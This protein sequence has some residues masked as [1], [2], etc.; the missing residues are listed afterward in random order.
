MR[1]TA[2]VLATTLLSLVTLSGL[3]TAGSGQELFRLDL[4]PAGGGIYYLGCLT[5]SKDLAKCGILSIWAQSNPVD[6]LQ[7]SV[8]QD[9]DIEYQPDNNLLS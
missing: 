7:T 2:L 6:G 5:G 8:Y 1:L 4:T 9:G 3:A